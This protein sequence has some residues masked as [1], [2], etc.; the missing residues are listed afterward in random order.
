MHNIYIL[1]VSSSCSQIGGGGG[2]WDRTK[3]VGI[4]LQN[5]KRSTKEDF[6][7]NIQTKNKT[8]NKAFFLTKVFFHIFF[9]QKTNEKFTNRRV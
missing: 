6:P 9:K 5:K 7:K 1:G 8:K 3:T 4:F 2:W